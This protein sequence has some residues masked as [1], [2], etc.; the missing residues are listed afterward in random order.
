MK[1]NW[2]AV[3]SNSIYYHNEAFSIGISHNYYDSVHKAHNYR[4]LP[5]LMGQLR[6]FK[7]EVLLQVEEDDFKGEGKWVSSDL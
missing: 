1:E 3:Y 7:A 6:S 5:L 4:K 2:L